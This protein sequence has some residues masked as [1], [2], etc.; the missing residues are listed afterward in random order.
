MAI[1]LVEYD[2]TKTPCAI[3]RLQQE[4]QTSNIATALDHVSLL[5]TALS[6]FFVSILSDADKAT[7]DTLVTNHSGIGLAT[8][9]IKVVSTSSTNTNSSSY[10]VVNSMASPYLIAGTYFAFFRGDFSTNVPLLSSPGIFI[11]MFNNGNQVLDSEMSQISTTGGLFTMVTISQFTVGLNQVVDL[12]WKT[13]GQGNTITC[14]NR[15][16]CLVRQK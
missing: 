5:D 3:D 16:L 14:V 7:L 1:N 12:R 13:N 6:I 2:Y 10:A 11:S 9:F 15:L 8:D 4:I